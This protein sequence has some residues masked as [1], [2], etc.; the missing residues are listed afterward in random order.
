V[1]NCHI[2]V[3]SESARFG[4]TEIK[5]G[6][7]PFLV[8]RAVESAVGERRAIE[9]ALTGRVF[10]VREA[11]ALGLIHEIAA[12]C[13]Q[14]AMDIAEGLSSSSPTAIRSGLDFVQEVRGKEWG[15]A[16][17]VARRVREEVFASADFQEG[18]RAFREKR[19]PKWPSIE[20]G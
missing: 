17:L 16:G 7:W 11:Q 19:Q 8:F 1:A 6:L 18:V 20:E 2:A 3:A 15:T 12:D 10:D 14:R 5:L 4:L 13:D 9:L